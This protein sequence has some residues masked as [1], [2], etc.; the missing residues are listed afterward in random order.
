MSIFILTNKKLKGKWRA[1]LVSLYAL[2]IL[3]LLGLIY[4]NKIELIDTNYRIY[5]F[6]IW[7]FIAVNITVVEWQFRKNL[8]QNELKYN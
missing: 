4:V 1:A 5:L 7:L 8:K 6:T 2:N 3:T